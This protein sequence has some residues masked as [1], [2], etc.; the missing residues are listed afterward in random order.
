MPYGISP[1][2]GGDSPSNDAWM[3]KCVGAISGTNKRTG[4]PYT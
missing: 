2:E 3:E 4:K 1:K